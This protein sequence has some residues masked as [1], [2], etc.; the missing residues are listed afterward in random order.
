MPQQLIITGGQALN[1]EVTISGAKNSALKLMCAALLTEEPVTLTNMPALKDVETL[2]SLFEF[3]GVTCKREGASL[4]IQAKTLGVRAPYEWVSKMRASILVLGPL[5]ARLGKAEV[6]MPGGCAIGDRPLDITQHGFE[7]MG[8]RFH[9]EHGMLWV[10]NKLKGAQIHLRLPSVGATENLMLGATLAEGTTVIENAACEPEMVDLANLLN[11]MGAKVKGAGTSRIEIQGVQKLHGATQA[12]MPDRIEAGSYLVAALL[13]GGDKGVTIR[14]SPNF[15]LKS[16]FEM[17]RSTGAKFDEVDAQTLFVP[18]QPRNFTALEL[19]TDYYPGIATDLQAQTMLFA[20]QCEG[21][22][23]IYEKIYENRMMHA[24]EL[25]NMN[26]RIEVINPQLALVHG[27]TKLSGAHVRC[28]DL[29]GGMAVVL[30]GLVAEGYTV[31]HD[32]HHLDRGYEKLEQKL[33]ALGA[34]IERVAVDAEVA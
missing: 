27:K 10:F 28:T 14:N 22:S 23:K 12:V 25:R 8:A 16:F 29:R 33:G 6:A 21:I 20:T 5:L 3:M 1:G 34:K 32:L 26:A 30:A 24:A 4:T 9:H 17:I 2:C 11:A 7:Q 19:M 18:P 31:V 13:V 15:A